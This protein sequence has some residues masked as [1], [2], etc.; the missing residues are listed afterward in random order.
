MRTGV[1][2]RAY[3]SAPSRFLRAS[4]SYATVHVYM[5]VCNVYIKGDLG[6]NSNSMLGHSNWR[7]TPLE[8]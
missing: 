3:V 6:M 2:Y 5:Y 4:S 1:G 7:S 8:L